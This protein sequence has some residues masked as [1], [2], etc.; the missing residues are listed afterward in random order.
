MQSGSQKLLG[1]PGQ[2][3]GAGRS[4]L[5][6]NGAPAHAF[7]REDRARGGHARAEKIRRRE[8][9]RKQFDVAELED[10]AAAEPELLARVVS[11]VH[12]APS[13]VMPLLQA[14]STN[15]G[16]REDTLRKLQQQGEIEDES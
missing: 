9:L 15:V 13:F 4:H 10:V 3:T 5:L 2:P 14:I 8:E 16:Q 11:R 12:L 6:K 1:P 7:T